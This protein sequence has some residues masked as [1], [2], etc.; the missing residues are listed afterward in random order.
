MNIAA[1][2]RVSREDLNNENQKLIINNHLK[3]AGLIGSVDWFFE[4]QSSRKT[5]PIKQDLINKAREGHYKIIIFA[6]IDRFARSTTE[7]VMDVEELIS[8][9]IRVISVQNGWDFQKQAYNSQ[10]MLMLR[11]FSAFAEFEREL[12]RERTL[13]GLARAKAQGKRLGRPRK[14]PPVNPQTFIDENTIP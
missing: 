4:M 14:T 11:L 8:I 1:Y 12:I 5:R 6:R 3:N 9:G 2:C 7:L 10:D 13:E